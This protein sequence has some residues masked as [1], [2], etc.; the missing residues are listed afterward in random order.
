ML[1]T[2]H[3]IDLHIERARLLIE[4]ER[5]EEAKDIYLSILAKDPTQ[6]VALNNLGTLLRAM[7]YHQAALKV[8]REVATLIPNDIKARVNP[9]Q[10]PARMLG[11]GRSAPQL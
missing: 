8:H 7:G 6:F 5:F 2:P 11:V 3:R 1:A 4:M 9:R 10:Q